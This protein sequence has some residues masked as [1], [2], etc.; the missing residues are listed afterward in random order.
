[1]LHLAKKYKFK[2]S[3]IYLINVIMV[4][5]ILFYIFMPPYINYLLVDN[6]FV[7][8]IILIFFI[9][10]IGKFIF[11]N[12]IRIDKYLV[13]IITSYIVLIISSMINRGEIYGSIM[14]S[15]LVLL[16]CIFIVICRN[17][18]YLSEILLYSIRNITF[19]IFFINSILSILMPNGLIE[20]SLNSAPEFIYGNI[21]SNFKYIIP[22][23]LCSLIID[24]K[25]GKTTSFYS[26]FFFLG[27][28]YTFFFIYKTMTAML[29]LVLI[30]IWIIARNFIENNMFAIFSFILIFIILFN[31][32]VVANSE[33]KFSMFFINLIGK[34]ETLNNRTYLWS[35]AI[36]LIRKN[37]LIGYGIQSMSFMGSN[38][39]NYFGSHNYYLDLLF[40]RGIVGS[41]FVF[42]L[43]ININKNIYRIHEFNDLSYFS[44]GICVVY[45][46][47]FLFEPFM[48]YEKFFIPLLYILNRELEINK[49][50]KR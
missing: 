16:I 44:L 45:L 29:G 50:A 36:E 42:K 19:L 9:I 10:F 3:I 28:L 2:K 20:V 46:F 17:D 32:I 49:L 23:I 13:W 33:W 47:M 6:N 25:E 30:F 8:N 43:I 24:R 14:I 5:I 40:T 48:N 39:G 27:T 31:I 18:Y 21:N 41:Y 11:F 38:V 12:K 37:I 35:N 26:I 4:W 22:G 7:Q 34:N 1:M 15:I